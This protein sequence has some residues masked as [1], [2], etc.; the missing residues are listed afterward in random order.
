MGG[1]FPAWPLN[2]RHGQITAGSGDPHPWSVSFRTPDRYHY[3]F[4]P[5]S[6][7]GRRRISGVRHND[8][9]PLP[10]KSSMVPVSPSPFCTHST[11]PGRKAQYPED[12][13][14]VQ[15]LTGNVH[16]S[17]IPADIHPAPKSASSSLG[18]EDSPVSSA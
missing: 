2:S 18:S 6:G 9:F 1:R 5:L 11:S 10:E 12:L 16:Q 15:V 14:P 3:T 7:S 13:L 4:L 8:T 17:V